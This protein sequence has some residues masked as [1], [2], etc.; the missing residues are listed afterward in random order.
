MTE[1]LTQ[2]EEPSFKIESTQS[3]CQSVILS[4][5]RYVDTKA[6]ELYRQCHKYGLIEQTK[7]AMYARQMNSNFKQTSFGGSGH[8]KHRPFYNDKDPINQRTVFQLFF[9]DPIA[10]KRQYLQIVIKM[11]QIF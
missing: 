2:L 11:V 6:K 9:K 10:Y 8:S 4:I 5:I 1:L 3:E 7:V